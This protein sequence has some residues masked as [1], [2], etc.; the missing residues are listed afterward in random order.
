MFENMFHGRPVL[1]P[2]AMHSPFFA[3]PGFEFQNLLN[4]QR[5]QPFLEMKLSY[6]ETW[7]ECFIQ[8]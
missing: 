8:I 7:F 4:F 2:K 1:S 5:L 3:T 6:Y